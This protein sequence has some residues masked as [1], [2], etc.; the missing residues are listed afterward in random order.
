[1]PLLAK[2]Q[3]RCLPFQWN[4]SGIRVAKANAIIFK[5]YNLTA[6]NS[7]RN[8][9][10]L[11]HF[12]SWKI[13]GY[14]SRSGLPLNFQRGYSYGG[15]GFNFNLTPE[16][17]IYAILGLN[18]LVFG[19]IKFAQ[20]ETDPFKLREIM[21]FIRKNLAFSTLNLKE[22][23]VWTIITS[24]FTHQEVW[25]L[26]FNA[27]TIY[28]FGP[29]LA[30][31]LGT[32]SFLWLYMLSGVSSGVATAIYN[33]LTYTQRLGPSG[34]TSGDLISSIGASGSVMGML[35]YFGLRFPLETIYVY[36][37][38]LP[39]FVVVGGCVLYDLMHTSNPV[40]YKGATVSHNAH[41]GGAMFGALFFFLTRRPSKLLS[42]PRWRGRY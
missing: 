22:G 26:L 24:N 27:M 5:P 34:I 19:G 6:F 41:L 7:S 20:L 30:A 39:A 32:R 28:F 29:T 25:H 4:V 1:M 13:R 38:P 31:V 15:S 3:L 18:A 33:K 14:N 16:N 36:F 42:N 11:R 9:I 35:T 8:F 21:I 40:H 37:I 17:L 23:R 10:G 2:C 12:T